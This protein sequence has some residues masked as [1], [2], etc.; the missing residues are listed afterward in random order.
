MNL[1]KKEM[2]KKSLQHGVPWRKHKYIRKEGDRYI[3]P[4]DL[5]KENRLK[6][7]VIKENTIKPITVTSGPSKSDLIKQLNKKNAKKRAQNAAIA[8]GQNQA[9]QIEN[10]KRAQEKSAKKAN[11]NNMVETAKYGID[12]NWGSRKLN[13]FDRVVDAKRSTKER[14]KEQRSKKFNDFVNDTYDSRVNRVSSRAKKEE[15]KSNK[16]KAKEYVL[17]KD[18][19][20]V[21]LINSG[22]YPQLKK[23]SQVIDQINSAHINATKTGIHGNSKNLYS[24]TIKERRK[25]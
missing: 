6:E 4:E 1:Y 17:T 18:V 15:A 19:G 16:Q 13:T 23:E 20:P 14:A 3:Y 7:N 9:K 22:Y 2:Y 5:V 25:K 21:D 11:I 8:N 24:R 10:Q 12:K